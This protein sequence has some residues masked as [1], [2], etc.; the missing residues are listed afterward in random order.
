MSASC[1]AFDLDDT[2]FLERDYVRSGFAAVGKW[3][4]AQ[5]GLTSF[6]E[7]AWNLFQQGSRGNIFDLALEEASLPAPR[8]T[9]EKMVRVYRS[10]V[11]EIRLTQDA[12]CCLD[13]LRG[14]VRL[15]LISDG[16]VESQRNK[17]RA[18]A[19]DTLFDQIILTA[20]LGTEFAKPHPR[21]FQ[22]VET[23]SRAGGACCLYVADN[24]AKDFPAPIEL[25]W[26]TVR[27]RRPDGLHASV[28]TPRHLAVGREMT[29]LSGVTELFLEF[30]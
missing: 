24:P 16:P 10:H 6:A 21:S 18:L 4:R 9:I 23:E 27:I 25:G 28:D 26:R 2:L 13:V 22:L 8:E 14:R 15:A 7:C 1:I 5:F 20:E 12:V 30:P 17:V 19:L 3:A 11:P 29:D